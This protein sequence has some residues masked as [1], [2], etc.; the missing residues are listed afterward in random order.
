MAG[1]ELELAPREERQRRTGGLSILQS[2]FILVY[3]YLYYSLSTSTSIYIL[4]SIYIYTYISIYFNI[5]GDLFISQQRIIENASSF[6]VS[7]NHEL[8]RIVVHGI[9]HLFGYSDKSEK[10]IKLMQSMENFYLSLYSK[11]YVSRET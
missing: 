7:I 1:L 6:K 2:I 8:L 3:L 10:D 9:L 5:Y 4:Y 11:K